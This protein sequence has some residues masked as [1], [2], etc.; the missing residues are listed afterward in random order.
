MFE[1]KSGG[2]TPA[3]HPDTPVVGVVAVQGAAF[4]Q[5]VFAAQ[6]EGAVVVILR[7]E[8]DAE[9]VAAT[10]ASRIVMPE[11]AWGWVTPQTA[12]TEGAESPAQI[13]YSSG[14][15]GTPKGIVLTHGNIAAS[16]D[17]LID[18][19]AM[20]HSIREY[21]G[22]PL[23]Y[24][25]GL[26]RAR[27]IAGVGGSYF[28]PSHG[29]D[30]SEIAMMLRDGLI[31][32]ISAVPTLWRV[33]LANSDVIGEAGS[34]VRWIEIGS[35]AMSVT[36]KL[37]LKELF[38]EAKIVQHYGLTEASRTTF[39]H[40]DCA[41]KAQL[42][43]VG[44]PLPGVEVSIGGEGRICIRGPH[45][46]SGY[47]RD[48]KF[49]P[50]TD[51]DGWFVTDD[52]G[53]I[54]QGW[55]YFENR[56]DDQ[57]NSG[58]IK[59]HP[60]ALEAEIAMAL[61]SGAAT[62]VSVAR[63]DDPM[64]GDAI[65]VAYE[66]GFGLTQDA[67]RRAANTAVEGYGLHAGAALHILPVDE[68]PRTETGKVL[69]RNIG[70]M[71]QAEAG[72]DRT[73]LE[74]RLV[75]VWRR[76]LGVARVGPDDN[77]FD[78]GGDPLIG[79]A[80]IDEM[81]ALG[82]S[83][84]AA[85]SALDG[86]S[87]A[88]IIAANAGTTGPEGGARNESEAR[89]FALWSEALGRSDIDPHKSFYDVGGDSLSAIG[90]ALNMERAGFEGDIARAIFDGATISEIAEMMDATRGRSIGELPA[91]P[92]TRVR[93]QVALLNEGLNI[94][95]GL[96]MICMAASH[97][98]PFYLYHF[99]VR[100]SIGHKLLQPLLSMG[101]P[102]LSFCFGIGAAVFYARQYEGSGPAFR[103]SIKAGVRLLFA[104]LLLG[105]VLEL[106]G[107]LLNG[108][109]LDAGRLSAAFVG[110][111]FLYFML[112]TASLPLW[113]PSLRRNWQSVQST[114]GAAI[115]FYA[116]YEFLRVVLPPAG[117]KTILE[118]TNDVLIGHWSLLQMGAITLA[119]AAIGL[120]I[121]L[122]LARSKLSIMAP[123]ALLL[124][125]SGVV[126]AVAADDFLSWFQPH[127]EIIPWA[128]VSYAGLTLYIIARTE[129]W[130]NSAEQHPTLRLLVRTMACIGI[131]LFPLFVIQSFVFHGATI[132]SLAL[133]TPF[134]RTLTVLIV[135][136]LI[137]AAF[138]VRRVYFLYYGRA[139]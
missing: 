1:V 82:I 9:R 30:P 106:G 135:L 62:H 76:V 48:G 60:D 65:V 36:E 122:L 108:E 53:R 52:I 137:A 41:S 24:S 129:A 96:L 98:L 12:S 33:L 25:F 95:K 99:H 121:E 8:G 43:S 126:M 113:V 92:R 120:V 61:P 91:T 111:P 118:S 26:G 78:L 7:S 5:A 93:T 116:L 109:V 46:A 55:L 54:E 57:I 15:T 29:F 18:A 63:A 45:V 124:M 74:E 115:L 139:R 6:A 4:A 112:A 50:L 51:A 89:L 138:A 125:A 37:A 101:S 21:I 134:L 47:L 130:N 38:P 40:I 77:F 22:V 14:T 114:L 110:G 27:A 2:M 49:G 117:E 11:V 64:R 31:N 90:L 35:Q 84:P 128:A 105:F 123:Y 80:L 17:R 88:E 79:H 87:I 69:R 16:T 42:V 68:L 133:H 59:L 85:A 58:G 20:D 100:G 136:V 127:L 44:Q 10:G 119:G 73:L 131:L 67:V 32:A 103:S 102:T 86:M 104:G 72:K 19:M 70:A 66:T 97:W 23:H 56:A 83:R 132:L 94:V 34:K 75:S 3:E 13:V 39:L 71:I 107:A 81:V 28:M